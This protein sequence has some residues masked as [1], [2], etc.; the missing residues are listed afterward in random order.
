MKIQ[1]IFAAALT[2][3]LFSG[4]LSDSLLSNSLLFTGSVTVYA[5]DS[6]GEGSFITTDPLNFRSGPS[7]DYDRISLI[8]LGTV[9]HVD[10]HIPGDFSRVVFNGREGFVHS[11][12]IRPFDSAPVDRANSQYYS[13]AST[14]TNNHTV[15]VAQNGNVQLLPWNEVRRMMPPGTNIHVTDVGTGL[16]YSIRNFSNGNHA[17]VEPVTAED[18]AILRQTFGGVWQWCPRPVWVTFNGVTVAAAING[19]PHDVSTNPNNNMNGHLCLHFFE[20]P[21]FGNQSYGRQMRD[22]VNA[23]F[24]ASR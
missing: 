15:N 14:Q 2:L 19:M 8:P 17:D 6:S 7:T 3:F 23:A 11:N 22:A 18:T 10:Q 16:T 9:I 5:Q 1:K 24:N 20:S 13:Q 4:L 12:Y 21:H